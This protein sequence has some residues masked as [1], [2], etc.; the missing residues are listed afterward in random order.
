[1][2]TSDQMVPEGEADSLR[3]LFLPQ[4]PH[5]EATAHEVFEEAGVEL[6]ALDSLPRLIEE[7]ERGAG[8]VLIADERLEHPGFKAFTNRLV[9]QPS[10][11]DLPVLVITRNDRMGEPARHLTMVANA[12][13]IERPVRIKPLVSTV[14]AAL[15]DRRR[16]YDLYESI[17]NRDQFLAM[18]GH[19]L[20]NPLAAVVLALEQLEF[21]DIDHPALDIVR[22]QSANLERIVDDLLEVS[23]I[24]RGVIS[25]ERERLDL[26]DLTRETVEAF[27]AIAEGEDLELSAD[28]P[29]EQM[30]VE[31]DAVR[32][33]QV[34]GN[35]LSNAVR[36][37]PA[38]GRVE[39]SLEREG[40]A[41]TVTVRDTGVGIPADKLDTIFDLF[42]QAHG[43]SGQ[44][45]G[46][47]GL[48]LSLAH[49]IVEQH[50]GEIVARSDG[51]GKG[52]AFSVRL[53]AAEQHR[54]TDG[55]S[56]DDEGK[57]A[58]EAAP[59][60]TGPTHPRVLVVEDAED[61]RLPFCVML[62]KRGYDIEEAATGQEALDAAERD[63]LDAIL[64]DI[65]LPD[66]DGYEVARR[67]RDRGEQLPIIALS[68][69]GRPEDHE[70]ADRAGI[71]GFLTK[72]V[73][74]DE[75]EQALP[76]RGE[77]TPPEAPRAPDP[78][79]SRPRPEV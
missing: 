51:E 46:G 74:V 31:G 48:G 17:T 20:R 16:Q 30:W 78:N 4:N 26:V 32:L 62:R 9:E 37:T 77:P 24:S 39:V 19:E 65:G 56:E 33:E 25:F 18:L 36:Y 53:P 8:C 44:S 57:P 1:M 49:S 60:E 42:A 61:V 5:D 41:V 67:L 29:D 7:I 40:D 2:T 79:D 69:F 50:D 47:L 70:Q 10:W 72:P 75:V 38:G 71:D 6:C 64:L 13:L 15:R 59:A 63:D 43:D 23:R 68:G 22:R 14:K 27:T 21:E 58:F 12:T 73:S 55:A 52:S 28:L 11:S 66:L 3:V 45:D 54:R 35:L 76:K 34:L